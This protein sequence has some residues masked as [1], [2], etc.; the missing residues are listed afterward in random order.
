MPSRR[1]VLRALTAAS[2]LAK[3]MERPVPEPISLPRT[4]SLSTGFYVRL[5]DG[6][7]LSSSMVDLLVI[8]AVFFQ[9]P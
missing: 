4:A 7:T 1:K 6:L 8:R 9:S 3:P 5:K 2:L